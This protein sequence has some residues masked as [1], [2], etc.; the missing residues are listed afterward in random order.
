M[1][2]FAQQQTSTTLESK[3]IT[4][5][6]SAPSAKNRLAASLHTDADLAFKGVNV[7]KGDYTLYVLTEGSQWQLAVSK[8][9]ANGA[10]YNPK[11][12]LGRVAM[13]MGKAASPAP[14]CKMAL[15]KIAALAAKLE[16]NCNDAVGSASFHLDRGVKDSEW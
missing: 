4:V 3:N 8:G 1:T 11:L 14:A 10:A 13:T 6:Y 5:K 7:P 2:A 15:S 9:G 12:D 16:V